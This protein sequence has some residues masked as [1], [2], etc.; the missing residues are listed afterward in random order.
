MPFTFPTGSSSI[1]MCKHIFQSKYERLYSFASYWTTT[2]APDQTGLDD[3]NSGLHEAVGNAWDDIADHESNYLETQSD[4]RNVEELQIISSYI[5]PIAG[6]LG[7]VLED[8]DLEIESLPAY[9]ALIIQKTTSKHGRSKRG[10][11][12]VPLISEQ[13]QHDGFID[14]LNRTACRELADIFQ[15]DRPIGAGTASARHWDRKNN[16]LEV[17]TRCYPLDVLGTRRD[18]KLSRPGIRIQM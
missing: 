4:F 7:D 8:A 15:T 6:A 10:R 11:M 9:S 2:V 3:F 16:K 18:R 1:I 13:I 12:F 14:T 5:S 17:I